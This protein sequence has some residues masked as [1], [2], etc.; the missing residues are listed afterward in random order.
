MPLTYREHPFMTEV[1]GIPS[2]KDDHIRINLEE[3]VQFRGL[4]T[5]LEHYRFPHSAL[6]DINLSDVSTQV[7]LFAKTL[8]GP[9]LTSS[10]T[11][12][13]PRPGE[14]NRRLATAAQA[15]NIAM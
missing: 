10:M 12:A 13:P 5:G 11:G 15:A 3:D 14:I 4:T 2:R 8:P 9:I 6:P 1:T 7:R